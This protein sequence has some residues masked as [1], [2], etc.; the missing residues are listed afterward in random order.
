MQNINHQETLK[1][2]FGQ[3]DVMFLNKNKKLKKIE[4]VWENW[5]KPTSLNQV[6]DTLKETKERK[7]IC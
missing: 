1:E 3:F 7:K 2:R 5:N 6:F 4:N